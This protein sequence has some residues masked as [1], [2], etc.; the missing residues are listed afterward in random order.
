MQQL[1]RLG[2]AL[3]QVVVSLRGVKA[4]WLVGGSCGLLLHGV[5][6][7][8][9][10]RDLD[11]YA[12]ANG[13]KELHQALA[14]FS[15]DDQVEDQSAIY[16]SILSHYSINGVKVELVGGFEVRADGSTYKVEADL[17]SRKYADSIELLAD[18][19]AGTAME[20]IK[21][22]P[23]EHE[24]IFNLLRSRPDRYEPI[25][26]VMRGRQALMTKTMEALILRNVFSKS[27]IDVLN[28]LL[29]S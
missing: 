16:R 9:P 5:A 1:D 2:D 15:V 24:L 18:D 12:D 8:A 29:L 25:A 28:K 6:L 21:L 17:L 11:L 19:T 13:V 27:L 14:A 20:P 10:P 3:K 22:M 7:A 23:L 4:P 26:A